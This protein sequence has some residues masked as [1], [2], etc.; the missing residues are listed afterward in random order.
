[1]HDS[2]RYRHN[3]AKCLLAAQEAC[4]P[5]SNF[6]QTLL[7]LGRNAGKRTAADFAS[8]W[9]GKRKVRTQ[10]MKL[11][12]PRDEGSR[13]TIRSFRSRCMTA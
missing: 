6:E 7:S 2:Q 11:R 9:I 12:K 3:A 8:R 10:P 13:N 4:P 1:M 5:Y